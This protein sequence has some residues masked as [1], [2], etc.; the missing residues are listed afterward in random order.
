MSDGVRLRL[1]MPA[2]TRPQGGFSEGM[3]S[4]GT[5]FAGKRARCPAFVMR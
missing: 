4:L 1:E 5:Y 2:M 3:P